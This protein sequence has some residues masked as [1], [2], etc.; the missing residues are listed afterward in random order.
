[1]IDDFS[2]ASPMAPVKSKTELGSGRLLEA[3]ISGSTFGKDNKV[4]REE[5]EQQEG[6]QV[7]Q[8]SV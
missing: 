5:E 1:M 7:G 3:H 4:N 2:V 6:G 8:H